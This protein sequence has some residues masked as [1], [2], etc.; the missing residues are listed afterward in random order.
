MVRPAGALRNPSGA[1]LWIAGHE[2]ELSWSLSALAG[3]WKDVGEGADENV[4]T[5]E[6]SASIRDCV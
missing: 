1:T 4:P 5:A 6:K 3:E 2:R